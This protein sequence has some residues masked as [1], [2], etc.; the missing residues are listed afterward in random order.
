MAPF[1]P[2]LSCA[3]TG[4]ASGIVSRSLVSM[5]PSMARSTGDPCS[6]A[7]QS[8]APVRGAV[9]DIGTRSRSP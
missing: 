5:N 6:V 8:A 3:E 2:A 7:V 9:G 1:Y 4:I